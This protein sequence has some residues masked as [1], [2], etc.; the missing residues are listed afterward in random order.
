MKREIKFRGK[1]TDNGEWVYGSLDS[2]GET[3]FITW[4][5][6]DS[7]GDTA[8][9][10]VE[11]QE[12]TIGQFTGLKD[13]NGNEIYEDDVAESPTIDPIFGDPIIDMFDATVIEFHDGAF[14]VNYNNGSR[15]IYLSDLVEYVTIKGN[16][17]DN[18]QLL[19]SNK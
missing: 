12:N 13:R 6:I 16:I 14:V 2:S 3:P 1:R 8:P 5:E 19:E 11:V 15:R 7:D 17:H 4:Q 18:P 10:F 9:W